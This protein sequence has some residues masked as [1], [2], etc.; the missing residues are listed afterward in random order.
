M[1]RLIPSDFLGRIA[2]ASA[3]KTSSQSRVN[4]WAAESERRALEEA[5]QRT[6]RDVW[7]MGPRGA[8]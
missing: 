1:V 5:A 2:T 6:P 4:L 8:T 7:Q 3:S